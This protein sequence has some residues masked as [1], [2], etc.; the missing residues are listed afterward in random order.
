MRTGDLSFDGLPAAVK[1][2]PPALD[3]QGHG[4]EVAVFRA[5]VKSKGATG[6]TRLR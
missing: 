1:R 2:L 3:G 4:G 6:P 5:N